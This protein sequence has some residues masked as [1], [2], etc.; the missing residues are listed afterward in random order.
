MGTVAR[1]RHLL[2]ACVLV[3]V[4]ATCA[5]ASAHDR[6]PRSVV[7]NYF[8]LPLAFEPNEGQADASEKFIARGAGY[9]L[10]LAPNSIRLG[11]GLEAAS[12]SVELRFIGAREEATAH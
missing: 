2:S 5:A 12:R 4:H 7:A 9:R 3:G 10:A 6:P 8:R 1:A 11:L